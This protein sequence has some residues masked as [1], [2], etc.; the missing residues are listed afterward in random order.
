MTT[1]KNDVLSYKFGL[2]PLPSDQ[3]KN[4]MLT[5]SVLVDEVGLIE[6]SDFKV[7]EKFKFCLSNNHAVI[8]YHGREPSSFGTMPP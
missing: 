6:I 7:I 3:A 4:L 8:T 2:C 5:K 1:H